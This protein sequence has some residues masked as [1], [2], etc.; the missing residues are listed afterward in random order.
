[1]EADRIFSK[2]GL[3]YWKPC[4]GLIVTLLITEA[5][6]VLDWGTFG[7]YQDNDYIIK[8]G[9]MQGRKVRGPKKNN[10]NNVEKRERKVE[11]QKKM[12]RK[13]IFYHPQAFQ[14]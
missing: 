8:V 4:Q 9:L 10:N 11:E 14:P 2:I 13:D 1:M 6:R 5:Y 3:I 12:K 7:S